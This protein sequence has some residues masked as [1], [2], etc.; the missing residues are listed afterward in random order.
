MVPNYLPSPR[1]PIDL[2]YLFPMSIPSHLQIPSVHS[3]IIQEKKFGEQKIKLSG[4]LNV[5]GVRA[6]TWAPPQERIEM[7]SNVD[8]ER[9]S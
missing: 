3:Q 5:P 4:Q 6:I 7:G 2:K 1:D 9:M 8:K